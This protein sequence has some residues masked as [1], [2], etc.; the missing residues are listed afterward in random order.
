MDKKAYDYL[1]RDNANY[2]YATQ[3]KIDE[4]LKEIADLRDEINELRDQREKI[5]KRFNA[6]IKLTV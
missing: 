1:L 6:K 5:H 2:I 3:R 4:R